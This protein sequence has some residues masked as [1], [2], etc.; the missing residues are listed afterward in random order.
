M[1]QKKQNLYLPLNQHK[2]LTTRKIRKLKKIKKRK[3]QF[4]GAHLANRDYN[5]KK[6]EDK[7]KKNRTNLGNNYFKK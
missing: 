4:S 3:M 6:M 1:K 2:T 5:R 7:N